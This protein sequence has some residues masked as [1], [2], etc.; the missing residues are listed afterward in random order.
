MIITLTGVAGSGKSTAASALKADGWR[1]VSLAAPMKT[2]VQDV[3]DFSDEQVWGP[4]EARNAIDPR[5]GVS[6]R[7]ALQQLGTEWGRSLHPDIWIRRAV[8]EATKD[9]SDVVVSDVRFRNEL[10]AFRLVGARAIRIVR[11]GLVVS[12]A[13]H[14][15]EAEQV[16]LP[17]HLFDKVIFN[18]GTVYELKR[19]ILQAVTELRGGR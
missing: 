13:S 19:D 17:D 4:S 3:F 8:R 1:E 7:Q 16:G 15:S 2:F 6:P 9:D 18:V 5:W 11:P 14:V 12:G 10:D